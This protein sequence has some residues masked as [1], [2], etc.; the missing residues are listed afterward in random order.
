MPGLN[1]PV[2]R[3][4][5]IACQVYSREL[6]FA[7]SQSPCPCTVTWLPQG[8]HNT[9]DQLRRR[10]QEQI[11]LLEAQQKERERFD[12][13]VLTYGLC[14]GGVCGLVSSTLP[15]AVPRCDDCIG[16]LLGAKKRYR[17]YFD[18]REG[19]YWYSP[20]WI[21]FGDVPCEEYYQRRYEHYR[22]LYGEDN[23][24][25]L[26]EC[27]DGWMSRY[28]NALFLQPDIPGDWER[29]RIFACQAAERFG[30]NYEA[31]PG[32]SRLLELLLSG[33]WPEDEVFVCPPGQKIALVP[34]TTELT[35]VAPDDSLGMT[36]PVISL[37]SMC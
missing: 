15:L 27:E 3:L 24:A 10:L 19:I 29:Y 23:A 30:W 7:L 4:A 22:A 6:S 21:D 16:V 5:V 17:A 35:S 34:G 33:R 32:S 1:P 8:L 25:Y 28:Q 26:V 31:V 20:G 37:N 11:G 18:S 36:G 2:L 13:I 14:G 9:P 12:A